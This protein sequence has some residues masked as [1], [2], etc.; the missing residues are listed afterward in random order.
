MA[1]EK[2]MWQKPEMT[3]LVRSRPEEAVLA[4]CKQPG[5][6]T[7]PST[8]KNDCLTHVSNVCIGDC[9]VVASS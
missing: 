4:A 7:G 5:S 8:A 1:A 3:V 9:T 6:A 2:T